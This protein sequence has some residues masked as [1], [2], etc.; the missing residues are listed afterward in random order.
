MPLW[1]VPAKGRWFVIETKD[2]YLAREALSAL[3]GKAVDPETATQYRLRVAAL[4]VPR[5]D[6][7][8]AEK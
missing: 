1:W 2:W 7:P 4:S 3:I 6:T 5:T 8:G